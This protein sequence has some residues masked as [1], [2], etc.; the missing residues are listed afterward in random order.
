MRKKFELG[1]DESR[2]KNYTKL[3]P[4]LQIPNYRRKIA[5]TNI[6]E[7]VVHSWNE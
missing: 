4:K 3:V 1:D 6:V 2:R 7:G 5:G